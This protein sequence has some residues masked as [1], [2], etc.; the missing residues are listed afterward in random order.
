MRPS[1]ARIW[2]AQKATDLCRLNRRCQLNEQIVKR[3]EPASATHTRL[4]PARLNRCL[5]H[6]PIDA[7]IELVV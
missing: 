2:G 6:S 5:L 4:P 7:L 3:Q 1:I